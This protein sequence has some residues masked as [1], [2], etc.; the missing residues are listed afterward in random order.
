MNVRH[1]ETQFPALLHSLELEHRQQ[2]HNPARP[3]SI[4]CCTLNPDNC[5]LVALPLT[6]S[7][8]R[9]VLC[10]SLRMYMFVPEFQLLL[11]LMPCVCKATFT[12]I[13][14]LIFKVLMLK[15]ISDITVDH[16]SDSL[17]W[18]KFSLIVLK[19]VSNIQCLW[20]NIYLKLL[21]ISVG[22]VKLPFSCLQKAETRGV[23]MS[24]TNNRL[25]FWYP[26][27]TT[28]HKTC[29]ALKRTFRPYL[30]EKFT[31]YHICSA[32]KK[33]IH[34]IQEAEMCF[35]PWMH[36]ILHVQLNMGI[37]M[38]S[39]AQIC[40]TLKF[41]TTALYNTVYQKEAWVACLPWNCLLVPARS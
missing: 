20:M 36:V 23:L 27:S 15:E 40:Q 14:N 24:W 38:S 9:M 17:L 21:V 31:F 1:L 30:F 2:T 10:L 28:E 41:L 29:S 19:L 5:L 22:T 16:F 13:E 7:W 6:R 34:F 33:F 18:C 11:P 32:D 12:A 3:T 39:W 26:A 37:S 25:S 8:V 35:S 4:R